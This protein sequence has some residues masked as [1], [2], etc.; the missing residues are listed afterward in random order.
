MT[1][2]SFWFLLLQAD[3]LMRYTSWIWAV[4]AVEQYNDDDWSE[5]VVGPRYHFTFLLYR[6]TA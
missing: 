1:D 3:V 5:D 2:S 6:F 4:Y